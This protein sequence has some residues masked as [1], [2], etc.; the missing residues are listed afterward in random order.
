LEKDQTPGGSRQK[1][2]EYNN[3]MSFVH[4]REWE[5]KYNE[6]RYLCQEYKRDNVLLRAELRAGKGSRETTKRKMRESLGWDGEEANLPEN[7]G[8]YCRAYLF[9]RYKFLKDK[10][11]VFDPDQQ[12]SLSDFVRKGLKIPE[13]ADYCDVWDRVIVPLICLKYTNMRC[14]INNDVRSAYKSEYLNF[15][16]YLLMITN[17]YL[18]IDYILHRGHK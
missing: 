13:S 16:I 18:I 14:N 7:V 9:P 12:N 4:G 3:D 17:N 2:G 6:L 11:D 10:W 8:Y 5:K 1:G 15:C